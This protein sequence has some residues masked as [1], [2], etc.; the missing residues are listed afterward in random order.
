MPVLFLHAMIEGLISLLVVLLV[1]GIIGAII[2]YAISLTPLDARLKQLAT[3]VVWCIVALFIL[4][5]ALP[6]L[7]VTV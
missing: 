2:V 7:G 5:R 4:V 1:A 3:I 6:L